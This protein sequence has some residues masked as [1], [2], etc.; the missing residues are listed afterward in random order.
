MALLF[1]FPLFLQ[2]PSTFFEIFG[3][4]TLGNPNLFFLGSPLL[5]LREKVRKPNAKGPSTFGFDGLLPFPQEEKQTLS[6][7]FG[8]NL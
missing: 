2:T 1:S 3:S 8:H 7:S 6:M 5:H 4:L